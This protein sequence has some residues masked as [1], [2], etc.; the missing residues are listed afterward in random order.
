LNS[1]QA[2]EY[3][4]VASPRKFSN[5]TFSSVAGSTIRAEF[6]EIDALM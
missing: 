6:S 2:L 5:S 1:S 4:A 3:S